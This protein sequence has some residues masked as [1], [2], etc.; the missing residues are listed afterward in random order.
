MEKG[1]LRSQ[2]HKLLRFLCR[3]RLEWG[4]P[5]Q[6]IPRSVDWYRRRRSWQ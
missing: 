2:L 1:D 3:D 4:S 5:S 6:G